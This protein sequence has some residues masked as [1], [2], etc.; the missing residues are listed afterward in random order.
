MTRTAP[1]ALVVA[2]LAPSAQSDPQALQRMVAT[3]RAFAAATGEIGVRDGFLTFFADDA[4]QVVAG[5]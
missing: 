1:L 5:H 2:L 3:E 4:V